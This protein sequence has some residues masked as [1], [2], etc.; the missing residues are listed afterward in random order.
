MNQNLRRWI[1][2]LALP[3]SALACAKSGQEGATE[4]GAPSAEAKAHAFG[5]LTVAE[6]DAK[7]A[8]AK[9]GKLAVYVFD[10]NP[11]EMW[12]Q[13]HVPGA[14]WVKFNEVKASDLPAD[15]EATLVFYCANES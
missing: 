6:L 8:E 14:K 11:K 10:N 3:L 15:K 4:K 9:T 5:E 2:L 7:L 1:A 13:G 12:E